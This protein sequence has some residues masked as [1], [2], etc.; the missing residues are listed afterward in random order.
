MK[1]SR[2][3]QQPASSLPAAWDSLLGVAAESRWGG[4]VS[5]PPAVPTAEPQLVWWRKTGIRFIPNWKRVFA[6]K[7]HQPEQKQGLKT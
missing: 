4:S 1:E 3:R 7:T 6:L 2:R 5:Q